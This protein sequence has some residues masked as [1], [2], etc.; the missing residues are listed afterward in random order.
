MA[1]EST[2]LVGPDVASGKGKPPTGAGGLLS[3]GAEP[4]NRFHAHAL[5]EDAR[6]H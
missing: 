2:L 3:E 1:D 6:P 5:H 4:L